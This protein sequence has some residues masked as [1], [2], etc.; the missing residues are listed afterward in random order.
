[1]LFPI[2]FPPVSSVISSKARLEDHVE[3]RL[4]SA[5]DA[6]EPARGE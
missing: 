1:L 5:S 2:A 4:R 3:G 6:A